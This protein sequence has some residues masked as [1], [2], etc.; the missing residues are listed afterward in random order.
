MIVRDFQRVIG[1]EA[2]AQMIQACGRLPNEL[3]AC[4]GGGSNS[5]GLFHPFLEDASVEMTG[6]EAGGTGILP[7]QHAARFAGGRP[8]VLQ[9]TY[10]YLLQDE[11]GQIQ[12]THSISAGLDYPAIGPEHAHLHDIG[13][14]R[15]T[16][17]SDAEALDAAF[18]LSRLEGIIP[19]LE[20]AHAIAHAIQKAPTLPQDHIILVGLSGR[21]DKDVEAQYVEMPS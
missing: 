14:V 17:V 20:S 7:G 9:G 5:I 15:Y 16:H 1:V 4:I 13:R 12:N 8:G 11:Q 19:A 3:I 2:R 6:V 21:G 18:S 10:T